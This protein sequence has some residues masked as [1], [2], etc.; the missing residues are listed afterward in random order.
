MY[1]I[2][3]MVVRAV[4]YNPENNLWRLAKYR[5]G[6]RIFKMRG[7]KRLCACIAHHERESRSLLQ[8]APQSSRV[9]D[10][11]SC[12]LGHI[13]KH[14]DTKL[15]FKNIVDQKLEGGAHLLRGLP[16]SGS[17]TASSMVQW[18]EK[19]EIN[20]VIKLTWEKLGPLSLQVGS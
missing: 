17:A 14:S 15:D 7:R 4:L 9:L 11:L 19:C 8:A 16:P 2:R 5:G 1:V 6:S 12:Y 3:G 20:G 10:S 13:L 18:M